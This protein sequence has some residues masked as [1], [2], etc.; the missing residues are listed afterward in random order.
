MAV[1]TDS[2]TIAIYSPISF[3][4]TNC[5]LPWTARLNMKLYFPN[6]RHYYK[7]LK[8]VAFKIFLSTAK[9][10]NPTVTTLGG[11]EL[12]QNDVLPVFKILCIHV[13]NICDSLHVLVPY[14]H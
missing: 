14:E 10:T 9:D 8:W 3:F 4:W 12:P 7:S 13:F 5:S 11:C 6:V 2:S 1:N